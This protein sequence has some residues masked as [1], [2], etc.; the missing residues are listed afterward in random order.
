MTNLGFYLRE[1]ADIYPKSAA[2]RCEAMTVSY[3]AL[4]DEVSRF[5][6]YWMIAAWAPVTGWG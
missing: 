5:A 4:A 1:S 2:L 6:A 3:A